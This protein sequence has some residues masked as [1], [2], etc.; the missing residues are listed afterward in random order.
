MSNEDNQHTDWELMPALNEWTWVKTY[1][2]EEEL[3]DTDV[4]ETIQLWQLGGC[5]EYVFVGNDANEPIPPFM[6]MQYG[7]FRPAIP[8]ADLYP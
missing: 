8:L 2:T 6:C 7:A 4:E 3:P 5:V 1:N